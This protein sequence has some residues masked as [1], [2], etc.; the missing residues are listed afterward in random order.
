MD[1]N[2]TSEAVR[3][4]IKHLALSRTQ[5]IEARDGALTFVYLV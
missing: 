3:P 5:R 4:K 1:T 2:M